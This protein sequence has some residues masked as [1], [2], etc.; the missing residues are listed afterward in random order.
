[1]GPRLRSQ[2]REQP[3]CAPSWRWVLTFLMATHAC[4]QRCSPSSPGHG[5]PAVWNTVRRS[6]TSSWGAASF[7][8]AARSSA[9]LARSPR[10][11]S[12]DSEATSLATPWFCG[13]ANTW[14]NVPKGSATDVG[15]WIQSGRRPR[16]SARLRD[17]APTCRERD[18]SQHRVTASEKLQTSSGERSRDQKGGAIRVGHWSCRCQVCLWSSPGHV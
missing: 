15:R 5:R 14:S 9:S 1:M 18:H 4:S 6:A 13:A 10:F 7:S 2:T 12:A 3:L 8:T 11:R 17:L 16:R